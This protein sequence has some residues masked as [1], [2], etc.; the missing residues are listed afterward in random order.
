VTT[1]SN[2]P[3]KSIF[4]V[5]GMD[6]PTEERLIRNRL[7]GMKGIEELHFNLMQR[8]LTVTHHLTDDA[9]IFD[10]LQKLKMEPKRQF[11]TENT[12]I[13]QVPKISPKTYLQL[14]LSGAL[15]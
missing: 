6:C 1:N 12:K 14:G 4:L 13:D 8:Q 15:A 5:Q 7:E 9:S 11:D 3:K 10:A 2:Q